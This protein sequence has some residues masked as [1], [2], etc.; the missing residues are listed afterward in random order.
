MTD[1]TRA[2]PRSILYTPALSLNRVVKALSYDADVHLID[3]LS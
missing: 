2:I 1:I 3:F